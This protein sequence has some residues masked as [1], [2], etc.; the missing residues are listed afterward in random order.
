MEIS[1]EIRSLIATGPLAHL[2]TLNADGSPQVSVVWVSIDGDE[3]VCGHMGMWQKLKN[4]RRDPRVV[5]TS[6]FLQNHFAAELATVHGSSPVALEEL[7]H[8]FRRH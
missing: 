6:S 8:G 5:L 7:D 3:F 4:V 2:S 1:K